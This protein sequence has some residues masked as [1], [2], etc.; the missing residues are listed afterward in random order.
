MSRRALLIGSGAFGLNL[1][2]RLTTGMD[3]LAG[4]LF[5]L[6]LLRSSAEVLRRC[7]N[8]LGVWAGCISCLCI[9]WRARPGVSVPPFWTFFNTYVSIFAKEARKRIPALPVTYPFETPFHAGFFGTLFAPEKSIFLFDSLLILAILLVVIA[10]KR[11]SPAVRA[12]VFR[13]D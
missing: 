5:V 10:W 13:Q 3:L 7:G 1:L 6:L 12:Y 4:I 8:G 9:F 2:T 11:L